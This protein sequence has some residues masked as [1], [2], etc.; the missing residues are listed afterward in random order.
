MRAINYRN[1]LLALGAVVLALGLVAAPLSASPD[2]SRQRRDIIGIWAPEPAG[3]AT[4]YGIA[5]TPAGRFAEGDEYQGQ[6]GRWQLAGSRLTETIT[7][8]YAA[9]DEVS[10]P[11]ITPKRRTYE[12]TIVSLTSRRMVLRLGGRSTGF[13]KCPEGRR[14]FMN[15]ETFP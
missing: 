1:P 7:L 3:C 12:L 11:R 2:S 8:G 9:K 14:L 13:V 6:E 4:G 5:F 15:G 10:K